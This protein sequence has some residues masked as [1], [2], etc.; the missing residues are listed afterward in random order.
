MSRASIPGLSASRTLFR[1]A[2]GILLAC[3]GVGAAAAA[4]HDESVTVV[5]RSEV[6]VERPASLIWPAL[7]D[8]KSWKEGIGKIERL[9]GEAGAQDELRFL[10]PPDGNAANGYFLQ[11]VRV[12]PGRRLVLKLFPKDRSAFF[13]FADF[14]LREADGRTTVSYDVYLDF[15]ASSLS[16]TQHRA[17][18]KQQHDAMK[19]KFDAEHRKLKALVENARR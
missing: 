2:L 11:T 12:V 8:L 15:A 10:T 16:E 3:F 18:R 14:N 6:I 17:W 9:S 5:V 1:R 19:S 7:L 13:G 4:P